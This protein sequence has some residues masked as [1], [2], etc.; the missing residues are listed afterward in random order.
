[1]TT[2][3]TGSTQDIVIVEPYTY[4][5]TVVNQSCLGT[6]YRVNDAYQAIT[7]Y[8]G[9][10]SP[11]SSKM[12]V[13]Y[14]NN[15]GTNYKIVQFDTSPPY[16]N[17][18]FYNIPGVTSQ[19]NLIYSSVYS[20]LIHNS[21]GNINAFD[22]TSSVVDYCPTL[23]SIYTMSQPLEDIDSKQ[24]FYLTSINNVF[25]L[26]LNEVN[27][28]E[29]QEKVID[30]YSTNQGPYKFNVTTLNWESMC[31]TNVSYN[32]PTTNKFTIDAQIGNF[33]TEAYLSYSSTSV[34]NWT[35]IPNIAGDVVISAISWNTGLIYDDPDSSFILRVT[36]VSGSCELYGPVI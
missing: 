9:D 10:G 11:N 36:F 35:P 23:T 7:Y 6:S 12:F 17:S 18:I 1:M 28:I 25:W 15:A 33:A 20:K 3:R 19:Q 24:I 31:T 2:P 34:N 5:L 13:V 21:G 16:N 32:T 26:G 30:Y 29:C 8:P 27:A 22:P 4:A 14:R